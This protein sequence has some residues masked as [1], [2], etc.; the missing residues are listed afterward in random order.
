MKTESELWMIEEAAFTIVIKLLL[1]S[2]AVPGAYIASVNL[3]KDGIMLALDDIVTGTGKHR[4]RFPI[5]ICVV[6]CTYSEGKALDSD[7]GDDR[8]GRSRSVA[9]S[10]DK[11]S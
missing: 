3:N 5:K 6:A 2:M 10:A 8:C 11:G 1:K 4:E 9:R 7:P